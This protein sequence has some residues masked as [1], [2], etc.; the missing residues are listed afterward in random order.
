MPYIEGKGKREKGR[1][2][3]K[4]ENERGK[5]KESAIS[6]QF[7]KSTNQV[8]HRSPNLKVFRIIDLEHRVIA[9]T[10]QLD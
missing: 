7:F 8:N 9:G 10:R 1:G 3:W 6:L 4:E 2:K 5:R